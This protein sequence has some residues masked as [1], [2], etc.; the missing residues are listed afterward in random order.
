MEDNLFKAADNVGIYG[1]F[2]SPMP[3]LDAMISALDSFVPGAEKY[4][5]GFNNVEGWRSH[6]VKFFDDHFIFLAIS[7][8]AYPPVIFGLVQFMKNREPFD[9][10]VPL[11]LWNLFLALFSLLGA[12]YMIPLFP[13]ALSEYGWWTS[14]CSRWCYGIGGNAFLVFLFDLSKVFEFVDTLFIV[15][16]K[17]PLIFLHYYHHVATMAFCWYCN[18]TSQDYGCHGFYFSTM[19]FFVH[20]VMYTYY[21]V[22]AMRIRIP[23]FVSTFITT[24]QIVQMI[25]GVGVVYTLSTCYNVDN[26]TVYFGSV[27]YLSFFLLFAEFFYKRYFTKKPATSPTAQQNSTPKSPKQ[28][29]Q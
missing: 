5:Q 22:M 3:G 26:T 6:S 7:L 21:A 10:R 8:L 4:I 1:R 12:I 14:V 19:N 16:R 15:L 2:P 24:M 25:I 29:S 11:I 20:F 9:L 23:N 27:L 28:K 17:K 13:I 18:Q